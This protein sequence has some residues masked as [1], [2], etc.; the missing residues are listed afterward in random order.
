MLLVDPD[1]DRLVVRVVPVHGVHPD[2]V[3]S[4]AALAAKLVGMEFYGYTIREGG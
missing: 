3:C 1:P 4:T 2:R